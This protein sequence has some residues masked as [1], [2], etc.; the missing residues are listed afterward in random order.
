MEFYSKTDIGRKRKTNQ[1]AVM[2]QVVSSDLAWSVVCD[3]MGGN[4]GGDIASR[5]AVEEVS[6]HM[7]EV[8]KNKT[9]TESIKNLMEYSARCANIAVFNKSQQDSNLSGMGTTIVLA[10]VEK[11]NLYLLH[12]GDS[13]AYVIGRYGIKQISV[14]HSIVQEMVNSGEI[15]ALEARNH[16]QKNII[17]RALGVNSEIDLDYNELTLENG[18]IVMLCTD[19]LSNHLEDQEIYQLF[20]K[21]TIN[22]IPRILIDKCNSRG[23]NDNITVSLIKCG[24]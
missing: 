8:L 14:D 23:G 11:N 13:R 4:N 1:D 2:G 9:D 22:K 20:C 17:T 24:N 15:T 16:S 12:A 5:M 7:V 18:D 3:G 6:R 10:V 21:H 19:G